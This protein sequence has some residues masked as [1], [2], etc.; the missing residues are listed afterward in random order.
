MLLSILIGVWDTSSN[1]NACT[2]LELYDV[3]SIVWNGIDGTLGRFQ[4]STSYYKQFVGIFSLFEIWETKASWAHSNTTKADLL[5]YQLDLYE[6]YWDLTQGTT[7]D[8]FVSKNPWKRRQQLGLSNLYFTQKSSEKSP[9]PTS[10]GWFSLYSNTLL[11]AENIDLSN[12]HQF[13]VE[14]EYYPIDNYYQ[15]QFNLYS[16][17]VTN[18]MKV[19][20]SNSDYYRPRAD[21]NFLSYSYYSYFYYV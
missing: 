16:S 19:T 21:I 8:G 7:F 2:Q 6:N 4:N 10:Q 18:F 12:S 1:S 20:T 17:S 11:F 14:F 5:S 13:T 15:I 3:S 9:Y